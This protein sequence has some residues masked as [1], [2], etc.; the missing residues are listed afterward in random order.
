MLHT[1]LQQRLLQSSNKITWDIEIGACDFDNITPNP[2][3]NTLFVEPVPFYV[4]RLNE[5]F[6]DYTNVYI[7]Q[8]ALSDSTGDQKLTY[9]EP[10]SEKQQWVRGISHLENESSNLIKRNVQLGHKLGNINVI[11]VKTWPLDYLIKICNIEKIEILKLDVEGHELKVLDGFSW[12]IK[13]E[14]I[15]IEHKFVDLDNLLAILKSKGYNCWNDSEDVFGYL[16]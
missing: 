5:K 7:V 4:Q 14:I 1:G 8:G 3:H 11:T 16:T 2:E 10:G 9:V 12:N 15:K 6:K 13:P